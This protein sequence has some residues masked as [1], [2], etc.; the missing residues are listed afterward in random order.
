VTPNYSQIIQADNRF[1][2]WISILAF[3]VTSI[4]VSHQNTSNLLLAIFLFVG[5]TIFYGLGHAIAK[6]SASG[7]VLYWFLIAV[8][9]TSITALIYITGGVQSPLFVLY[10][11]VFGVAIYHRS[12][13]DMVFG[14]VLSLSLYAG[15]LL[16]TTPNDGTVLSA[17]IGRSVLLVTLTAVL[18][19]LLLMNLKKETMRLKLVSRAKTLSTISDVLSGSLSNSRDWIKTVNKMIEEEIYEDGLQCRIVINRGNQQFLPPSGEKLG[20]HFPIMVGEWMFGTLIVNREKGVDFNSFDQDFF[21]SVARSLGLSLHR[22]K[23]WE[24]FQKKLEEVS[25]FLDGHPEFKSTLNG[26]K[27]QKNSAAL[28]EMIDVIKMERQK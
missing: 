23:L 3:A 1:R 10:L 19:V 20:V 2:F 17:T 13:P 27:V 4:L 6:T 15:L 26:F 28:Q 24:D 22:A 16:W 21:S 5:Y 18:Y 7:I 8:D 9:A 14:S 12:M 25:N 11:V